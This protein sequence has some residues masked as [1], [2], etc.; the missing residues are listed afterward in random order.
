MTTIIIACIGKLS[1]SDPE[2]TIIQRY[3]K[4]IPWD[5]KIK[6]LDLKDSKLPKSTRTSK[7]ATM[8]LD[9]VKNCHYCI[10]L[11]E[12]GKSLSSSEFAATL[13]SQFDLGNRSIGIIIGGAYGLDKAVKNHCQQTLN[14]GSMTWPH[15]L[16]RAM[17][18]EQLYRASTII[19]GHPYHK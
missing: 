4:R 5:V 3:L 17:I 1:S 11:D 18:T 19:S 8:L 14:L 15:M 6:E 10:A 9:A 2:D 13:S 16:A 7:E 12:K